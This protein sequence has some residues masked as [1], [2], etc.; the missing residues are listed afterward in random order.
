LRAGLDSLLGGNQHLDL[1]P[2]G[3]KEADHPNWPRRHDEHKTVVSGAAP[4]CT[5]GRMAC[6]VQ[7]S[8]RS[9]RIVIDHDK[10]LEASTDL[11]RVPLPLRTEE[12]DRACRT[13]SNSICARPRRVPARTQD[14]ARCGMPLVTRRWN[15]ESIWLGDSLAPPSSHQVTTAI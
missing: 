2:E 13:Y 8:P 5:H 12:Y 15:I 10:V 9:P 3:R 14:P 6:S 4:V 1:T 7:E 11:Q